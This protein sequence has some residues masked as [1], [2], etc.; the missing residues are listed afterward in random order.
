LEPVEL[1]TQ[2]LHL[3]QVQTQYSQLLHQQVA[4]EEEVTWIHCLLLVV[5]VVVVKPEL[6]PLELELLAHLTKATPEELAHNT[7]TTTLRELVVVVVQV[8]L[9]VMVQAQPAQ[10][11]PVVMEFQ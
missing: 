2:P 11:E 10:Q 8:L 3:H 5:L 7:L 6:E 4:V 1:E 9:E